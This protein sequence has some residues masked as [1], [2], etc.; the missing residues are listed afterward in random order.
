MVN[1]EYVWKESSFVADRTL[2]HDKDCEIFLDHSGHSIAVLWSKV[3]DFLPSDGL[4]FMCT[5][6]NICTQERGCISKGKG[7]LH[8]RTGHKGPEKE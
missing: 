8:P 3:R 1:Y 6:A 2:S 5:E 7:T 4:Y